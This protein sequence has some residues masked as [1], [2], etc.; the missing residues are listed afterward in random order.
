M[1]L[2]TD[3]LILRKWEDDDAEELYKYAKDDRIGPM[4][5]WLPHRNPD[6]SLVIIREVLKSPFCFAMELKE[7]GLPIGTVELRVGGILAELTDRDDEGELGF[8]IGVP[9]WGQGFTTEASRRVMDF[10][11]EDLGMRALWCAYFDGN[12][13]SKRVQEK[14]GFKYVR[15]DYDVNIK[16]L[17]EAKTKHV[18]YMSYEDYRKL[19][20]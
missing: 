8:W 7:T 20:K 6:D 9:Y 11:F 2:E 15:T 16:P 12:E 18:N 13:R 4:C 5:G 10:A 3:R 17:G 1:R 19:Y 14:L